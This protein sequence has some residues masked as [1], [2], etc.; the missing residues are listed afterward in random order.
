MKRNL[1]FLTLIATLTLSP[2]KAVEVSI[3][4]KGGSSV[5][6]AYHSP[7]TY[8]FTHIITD[9]NNVENAVR[10]SVS[11]APLVGG[12]VALFTQVGFT[13]WY[14][15]SIELNYNIRNGIAYKGNAF[16]TA[17][18]T[19]QPGAPAIDGAMPLTGYISQTWHSIELELLSQFSPFNTGDNFRF[20]FTAGPA[21][22]LIAGK[23]TETFDPSFLGAG[24]NN[25]DGPYAEPYSDYHQKKIKAETPFNIGITAGF[26]AELDAGPGYLVFDLRTKWYFLADNATYISA[27]KT[28]RTA[29]PLSINIGYALRFN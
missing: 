8:S 20:F 5:N 25:A 24:P 29:K 23:I 10:R 9:S 17:I 12:T 1:L 6:W 2:L 21:L 7:G 11:Q 26:S 4:L 19:P 13:G 3:G 14:K 18:D 15:L 27:G 16:Q 28:I 22:S